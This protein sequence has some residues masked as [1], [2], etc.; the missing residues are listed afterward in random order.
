M[1]CDFVHTWWSFALLVVSQGTP[2][3]QG[4]YLAPHTSSSQQPAA[5]EQGLPPILLR[6]GG[7][8]GAMC[9]HTSLLLKQAAVWCR[10]CLP[11]QA[12]LRQAAPPS[13]TPSG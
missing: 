5:V 6:V 9:S 12:L 11:M 7:G 10:V 8:A 3:V 2:R 4:L 13:T 1:C